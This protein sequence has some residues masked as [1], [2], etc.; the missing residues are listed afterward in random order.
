MTDHEI[1]VLNPLYMLRK[2]VNRVFIA[3]RKNDPV[4]KVDFIG[5]VH[6][7]FAIILSCFDGR[8]NLAGTLTRISSI[9]Q[10]APE[11][12]AKM[13]KPLL[14]NEKPLH[15]HYESGHF[16]FP[17]WLLIRADAPLTV[18][19][20]QPSDYFIPK[21]KL[22]MNS[23]R[24]NTPLDILFMVNTLC[25]T[26]CVYCYADRRKAVND[27]IPLSR[28]REIIQE[29][30]A[31]GI[32]S[33]DLTGGELFLHPHWETLLRELVRNGYEPI[34]STKKP[35]DADMIKRLRDTGIQRIQI[36][37]D[38]I[39]SDELISI[40]GVDGQYRN[41]LL[42][43]LR[44]LDDQGMEIH[45]NSQLTRFNENHF[46]Q[47][48]DFLLSL[49]HLRRMGVGVAGY[50][51]YKSESHYHAIRASREKAAEVEATVNDYKKRYQERVLIN[52]SDIAHEE[53]LTGKKT[54]EKRRAFSERSRCSANF[55]AFI[56]LPDGKVT[57]CE[58]LYWHP[59]FLIG[60]LLRQS[61]MEVWNSEPALALHR[62]SG[63]M[64]REA[65]A[66]SHCPEFSSCRENLGVCWKEIL[67]AYGFENWD[68]PDPKCP[69]AE[70]PFIR[71]YH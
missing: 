70:P 33:F 28:L 69:Y 27:G 49:K 24:L 71:Y 43:T 57:I 51:L 42:A 66:C 21:N 23:Q 12:M 48:L 38:S 46:I 34:V 6:P 4:Q 68:Y 61:I 50:S 64:F 60:D 59:R 30:R 56:I 9:T 25:V 22:D 29:A 11:K 36:S 55:Y 62:Q 17:E 32:R 1:Y 13:I 37:I 41:R 58:E 47:L 63:A 44:N 40:L 31:L 19:N 53:N 39:Q 8:Q 67:Y 35:L 52:F 26:D 16:S 2:D 18:S 54:E 7:V 20:G 15:F 5:M 10:M 14:N 65:S 45:T 3:H